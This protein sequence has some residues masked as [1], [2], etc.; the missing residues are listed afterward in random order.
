M[1]FLLLVGLMVCIHI[2][3]Q[4]QK[5]RKQS[6]VSAMW[7]Q[8]DSLEGRSLPR[9]ALVVVNGIYEVS[10]EQRL[11]ADFV[12]SL[13]YRYKY[14][15][16]L[17]DDALV[18]LIEQLEADVDGLW[19]VARHLT[20][21]FLGDLYK[22]YYNQNRWRLLEQPQVRSGSIKVREMSAAEVSGKAMYH[23]LKSLHDTDVLLQASTTDYQ[24]LLD[25]TLGKAHLRPSLYDLLAVKTVEELL[26]GGLFEL[27]DANSYAFE[28]IG[29]LM[30][31]ERFLKLEIDIAYADEPAVRAIIVL[32][33]WLKSI[34]KRGNVSILT[35]AD[36]TRL[37]LLKHRFT[38]DNGDEVYEASL[39]QII[40]R[41]RRVPE[42]SLA[43]YYRALFLKSLAE[44]SDNAAS[45]RNYLRE[46]LAL[47]KSAADAYPKSEG[48]LLSENLRQEILAPMLQLIGESA[49]APA[50]HLYYSV[51]YKNVTTLH[52]YLFAL[53]FP[54]FE[55][56]RHPEEDW[57]T[58]Q[59]NQT[60]PL[61]HW[62]TQ[63]PDFGDFRSHTAEIRAQNPGVGYYC[64]LITNKPFSGDLTQAE[65]FHILPF[66]VSGLSF[67]EKRQASGSLLTVLDRSTGSPIQGVDVQ[68][69]VYGWY[70]KS[71]TI[72]RYG[73][74]DAL[75]HL[76]AADGD[77]PHGN[78][79]L[80]LTH[81]KDTYFSENRWW[82]RG[83]DGYEP[84][85]VNRLFLFSDRMV[86][87]PGQSLLFKGVLLQSDG[88]VAHVLQNEMVEISLRDVNGREVHKLSLRT[89]EFGSV[90][91]RFNIP[92]GLLTG[93]YMLQSSF[94]THHFQV[95]EYKRPRFEVIPEPYKGWAV[96]NDTVH[97]NARV[98]TF[99][100][101]PVTG[102]S[103][104]WRV[105]RYADVWRRGFYSSPTAIASGQ[106]I[107]NEQGEMEISFLATRDV[108]FDKT[109]NQN[110]RV[111][112]DVTDLS[113]E[114]RSAQQVITLGRDPYRQIIEIEDLF[115]E[116][117]D[118]ILALF[119]LV[120]MS[121][122]PVEGELHYRLVQ[123][124]SPD[125]L[126]PLRYWSHPDTLLYDSTKPVFRSENES[127]WYIHH[128]KAILLESGVKV[129]GQL[130]TFLVPEAKLSAGYYLL[131]T[132]V[133]GADGAIRKNEQ[134]FRVFNQSGMPLK[135][136][137]GV[138]VIVPVRE[139]QPGETAEFF[140]GSFFDDGQIV[141][142]VTRDN[143]TILETQLMVNGRWHRLSFPVD[144][145]MYGLVS[146]Q[147]LTVHGNRI[148]SHNEAMS[149]I[150][151]SRK[152]R[153]AL[154]SFRDKLLPGSRETWEMTFLD[155]EGKPYEAEAVALMYDASLDQYM[156]NNL[157]MNPFY[158]RFGNSPW[159]WEGFGGAY[160]AGISHRRVE[161]VFMKA[162]PAFFWTGLFQYHRHYPMMMVKSARA[163]ETINFMEVDQEVSMADEEAV[164]I[165]RQEASA[166][167]VDDAAGAG[168]MQV[169]TRL[170]ETALFLP[171]LKF[172][173]NGK[174]SFSF[175]MPE[176]V[177]RWRFMA[178]AHRKDGVS[179]TTSEVVITSRDLMIVPN[180]PRVVREGD[181]LFFAATLF[182]NSNKRL[183]G[184]AN[185]IVTDA[186][187]GK[188]LNEIGAPHPIR[189]HVSPSESISLS[190]EVVVPFGVRGIEVVVAASAGELSDGERHVIPVLPSR[191]LVTETKP[192]T[193]TR[194]GRHRIAL[195]T[196]NGNRLQNV[197]RFT[198]TYT[199]NAAWE[200]LSVLPWLVEQP[201]ASAD[202]LFNRFYGL[203][204]A[205]NITRQN[206]DIERVLRAWSLALPGDEDA[207][208]SALE[209]NPELKST[210]LA[211]TPWF[212]QAQSES[213]RKRELAGLVTRNELSSEGSLA[214]M[215]LQN[216]QLDNG[217]WPW[218]SGMFPSEQVTAN[219]VA[220]FGFLYKTGYNPDDMASTMVE[221]ACGW[222]R[223]ELA[224]QQEVF[225][226]D[227][228]TT[229]NSQ[230]LHTL[231]ALS[232]FGDGKSLSDTER[233][234]LDKVQM[235]DYK[236]SVML[237]SMMATLLWRNGRTSEAA[238]I[239][240]TL[241]E[242]LISEEGDV[243]RFRLPH[244][245]YWHQAPVESHVAALEAFREVSP[246][247]SAIT[248]LE[249]WLI[250]QKRTQSWV[251]TRATVSAVYALASSSRDLFRVEKSDAIRVL[252]QRLRDDKR[253]SGTGF[254]SQT[255]RGNE[256]PSR[257]S[258]VIIDKKSDAP[259]WVSMHLS[260]F[261]TGADVLAGGF[262]NVDT[263]IYRR[264]VRDGIEEWHVVGDDMI[265]SRGDRLMYRLAI[266]TPQA[267]DFVHVSAPRAANLEPLDLLSGYRY[268]S[269][270][271]YYLSVTDAGSDMFID[272]LPKGR[273][274]LS[275]EVVVSH[276]GSASAGPVN[277]SCFY[278][279]DFSG[280]GSGGTINV[281]GKLMK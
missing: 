189:W 82:S 256:L 126:L 10:R 281:T 154:S 273:Y 61:S 255:W 236:E 19:P 3:G 208:L 238:S 262:L 157:F 218:F 102:A 245:P 88:K 100:G 248:G 17:D 257:T 52:S 237:Q 132:E 223:S 39:E 221:K 92:H 243:R 210:V 47:T 177:T 112:I 215:Q 121:N 240:A 175:T 1:R 199:Q 254:I 136:V 139:Y 46:A 198:F 206:P 180:M 247:N 138:S 27:P 14:N 244:G 80:M 131:E 24:K 118:S 270:L 192:V 184:T 30:P 51:S 196:A 83:N 159:H 16:E 32:Q 194:K 91:G 233:F 74:T 86:Y 251:T 45:T 250:Q 5:N 48:A 234:W 89:N 213:Q 79:R 176:S 182:N 141:V 117:N 201:H 57:L 114:T 173:V 190:W 140:V 21:A 116:K 134:I 137:D 149:V 49:V 73:I 40:Q 200:V 64:L 72:M 183:S 11:T 269:G 35:D 155:D 106:G 279:P 252:G 142:N 217:A 98:I 105:E 99:T 120:N 224:R 266:E 38:G 178:L 202:Q 18:N 232:F 94:G 277:V 109:F 231:Y 172:D 204:V 13:A 15:Q 60:K 81:G 263:E 78:R 101:L 267:L 214:L 129:N 211:A 165:T 146:I 113:G 239:I 212:R 127:E 128:K 168:E 63:L 130:S 95:E 56:S 26:G 246:Q 90:S 226:R 43:L 171:H 53:E 278:A 253:I 77:Q 220:G 230:V 260:R 207:L 85:A 70:G 50:S 222:L 54:D 280:Y 225:I 6:D 274:L 275:W 93:S 69:F 228:L 193:L 58:T 23:Y 186:V 241:E 107:T 160:G 12:R 104:E 124:D 103:Y 110:F 229:P 2:H 235:P 161:P 227:S 166:P 185:L 268:A 20:H 76:F 71:A 135:P 25:G 187:S 162:Y 111:V 41:A 119:R 8:V 205:G 67:I 62:T 216:M 174:T 258:D 108:K 44:Q 29:L 33:E 22:H 84:P 158:D 28:D 115:I 271:G 197:E 164:P 195:P 272:H 259:S 203:S 242:L 37:N 264:V 34:Q 42:Y 147:V 31:L 97:T 36:L 96:L 188:Q 150:N 276:E 144:E 133:V 4:A 66:Q 169:R 148:Y 143:K 181:R 249:N 145:S 68:S 153:L 125:R 167:K 209:H 7:Q 151:P 265:L 65:I 75:G 163:N 219:I 179:S 152:M 261:E 9:S 122:Q 55:S 170:E 191:V 123:L 156:A 87:R 59:I